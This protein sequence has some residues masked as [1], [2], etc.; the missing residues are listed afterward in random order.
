MAFLLGQA[1]DEH[2]ALAD[3]NVTPL[4][5]V[6]LVLLIIFMITAPMLHQG[7]EVA[8]PKSDAKTL[9]FRKEDPIVLSVNRDGMIYLKDRPVHPSK[10]VEILTPLL[11]GRG[12]EMVFVKGDRD[13]TYG[14]VIELFDTLQRGG[15][16]KVGL[17][18]ERPEPKR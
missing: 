9:P 15:I 12:D 1:E 3:I 7:I 10:I 16:T 18:T 5:D 8:L 17:V 6:M 11:R 14:K 13:V 2:E 4:V